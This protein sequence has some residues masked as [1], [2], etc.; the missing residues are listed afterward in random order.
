[1]VLRKFL[2]LKALKATCLLSELEFH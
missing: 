2:L 1:L